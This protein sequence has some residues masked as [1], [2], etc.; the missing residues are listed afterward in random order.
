MGGN[1]YLKSLETMVMA[2]A[3]EYEIKR[4]KGGHIALTLKSGSESATVIAS[5]TPSDHR[6]ILNL[7]SQ[8]RRAARSFAA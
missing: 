1:K 4:T 8:L 6:S 7:R 2:F 5:S 3:K